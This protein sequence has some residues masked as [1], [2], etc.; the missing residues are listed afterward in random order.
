M[1]LSGQLLNASVTLKGSDTMAA[2]ITHVLA[3]IDPDSSLSYEGGGSGTGVAA[4]LSQNQ[5]MAPMSR[6]LSTE[7]SA[8]LSEKGWKISSHVIALDAIGLWV[9]FSENP[10]T[11]LTLS[12]LKDIYTCKITQWAELGVALDQPVRA[13]RRGD[14]SGTTKIF[15]KLTGIKNFGPCIE[16]D[17]TEGISR[18][19]SRYANAIGFS[20][21]SAQTEG[22]KAL[23]IAKETGSPAYVPNAEN[24]GLLRYPLVRKLRLYNRNLSAAEARFIIDHIYQGDPRPLESQ[25]NLSRALNDPEYINPL[26]EQ[27]HFFPLCQNNESC[28]GKLDPH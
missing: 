23:A 27:H 10:A 1:L 15:M 4:L 12:Q 13:I 7:E 17:D 9:N 26:L 11:S 20:G 6:T 25:F 19:T 2:L 8:S 21:M 28:A 14:H 3:D 24:V 16:V 5:V 18:S 22:N